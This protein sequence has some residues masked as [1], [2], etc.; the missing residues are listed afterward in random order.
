MSQKHKTYTVE[1]KSEA[2]KALEANQGNVSETVRELGISMQTLSHWNNK[3]KAGTLA[4]TKQ[5]SPDLI[6]LLEEYKQLK[7]TA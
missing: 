1:L 4:G 6:A 2:I 7:Q 3:A 5:Y